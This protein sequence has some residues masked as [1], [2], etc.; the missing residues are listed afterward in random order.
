MPEWTPEILRRLAG[1]KLSPVREAE[2]AEEIEQHL[3]DRYQELLATD[4]SPDV[5]R[6]AVLAELGEDLLRRELRSVERDRYR[7]PV[8]LGK[9]SSSFFAGV[10]QDIRYAFRMMRNSPGF[11]AI[12]VLT[13]ALGIG[14]NVAIFTMMNGLM[15]H[16]LPVRD[17]GRLVEIVHHAAGEPEPGFNGFFWDAYEAMRDG[18]RSLSD[19]I[20]GS[21]NVYDIEGAGLESQTVF[22][23]NVGGNFF[24]ALG[25]RP[26]TGR[27]IGEQD[28]KDSSPVA[29]VSWS[30]W[31]SRFNL[32]PAIVGQKIIS[33]DTPY[34]II[35]VAQS[36]FAGL[37]SQTPQDIWLPYSLGDRS[38]HEFNIALQGHLKPGVSVQQAQTDLATL[39]QATNDRPGA[40]PFMRSSELRIV[41]AGN[42]VSTPLTQMLSTPLKVLMA[43]VG[44]LL[45]L[46]CANLAGLLLARGASRQ[47]EMAVRVS[48]GATR[49]RL[50]RQ[51]LT[52]SLLLSLSG[53]AIGVLLAYLANG[54][55]IRVFSS[56]RLMSGVPIRFEMLRHPDARVLLFTAATALLTGLLCGAAP[57]ISASNVA[58]ATALLPGSKI[59]ETK[60]QRLFGKGLVAAQVAFSLVLVSLAGLFV[61]YLSHLRSN[62]GFERN[63][64]LLVTLD[65][66]K[67]GYDAA[68][69]SHRSQDLLARLNAIPGVTSAT[70]SDMSPMEGPASTGIAVPQGRLEQQPQVFINYVAQDYFKTY[71]TSFLA[72]RDF[73]THDRSSSR[74]AIINERAARDCF[75]IDNPVG[76]RITLNHITDTKEEKT[77]EVIGVVGD[78]KYNDLQLPAPPTIY[79]N[80]FQEGFIASQLSVRTET[81]L[82]GVAGTVR[83]T[84][85][86]TLKGVP[87]V[88]MTPMKEQVDSTIVPERLFATLSS[89]FGALGALLAVIGLYGLLAYSVARRTREIGVRM[90][91]GAERADVMR[92]VVRDALWMVLAG[93]AIGAPLALWGKRIVASVIPGLPVAGVL[94]IVVAAA[95]MIAVSLIAAYL[96]AQ[97]A[98]RVDPIVA[99]RYE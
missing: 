67:S 58:P 91:L 5:A 42:G 71:G 4:Q 17:A 87:V 72:G 61:G 1:L 49:G 46:A 40:N 12:A 8:A 86:D 55:L 78:A 75:G 47:H 30:L 94:P 2:I 69:F 64:L 33:G 57:A 95:I 13:F 43:T 15:L 14:A 81:D 83:Q 34:T 51:T 60:R 21:M 23:G 89:G 90:A 99:L 82:A 84:V 92:I 93:V 27:L 77:Y 22:G 96:P 37:S 98:T 16:P 29:V 18:N 68:Q 52:E 79:T 88:H 6:Q 44:L 85:T 25:V 48:L 45:L 70:F 3:E 31:K 10:L 19:L 36:G 63:N 56:G 9:G 76:K 62:L 80:L 39:F 32:N 73:S 20:I 41:P 50:L 35:G 74:F 28:I 53:S 54:A 97:R 59:G 7:E 26:A 38:S 11:T 65:F 24:E 66:E